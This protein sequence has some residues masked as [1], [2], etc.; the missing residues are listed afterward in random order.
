MRTRLIRTWPA[1]ALALVVAAIATATLALAAPA[2]A[3]P[4]PLPTDP[5]AFDFSDCP[6][7]PAGLDP[8]GWQCEVHLANGDL[9]I[10]RVRLR[11]V[12]LRLVHAEGPLPSGDDGQI[13]GT[14]Q[15]PAVAIPAR[16]GRG[17]RMT[18]QLRYAGYADLI[19]NGPDPGGLYLRLAVRGPDL[20]TNCTIGTLGAP[21][22]THAARVGDTTTIS[23]DP[24]I[25]VFTLQDTAFTVPAATDCRGHERQ[26]D[27][28]L[29]L[30]ST[31]GN[32]MTLHAEYTYQPY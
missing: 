21:V 3:H 1:R 28:R 14:L 24:P 15:S 31:G 27:E 8:T 10:G 29:G 32:T 30:P 18:V 20:G 2:A 13:F 7:L 25:R 9:T 4:V 6:T 26:V 19:G 16:G 23:T 5:S 12:P 17:P 22:K 11:D